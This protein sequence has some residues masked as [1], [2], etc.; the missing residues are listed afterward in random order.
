MMRVMLITETRCNYFEF[1][2]VTET[3]ESCWLQAHP[4]RQRY[5]QFIQCRLY[6][7]QG[8]SKNVM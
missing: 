7:T 3:L 5:N 6:F 8:R 2:T 1:M 4:L